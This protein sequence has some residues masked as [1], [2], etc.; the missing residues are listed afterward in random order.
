MDYDRKPRSQRYWL[1]LFLVAL[2][3][4][5]GSCR[6][7]S[8]EKGVADPA[9]ALAR[10]VVATP[11][12]V[13]GRVSH[14]FGSQSEWIFRGRRFA[15]ENRRLEARIAELEG[16]NALLK[17]KTARYDQ[18]RDD[19]GFVKQAQSTLL[20]ADILSRRIDFKFET[21]LVARGANDGVK[22]DSVV[23]T[24]NGLVGRV[25]EVSAGNAVVLLITDLKSGVGA[26]VQR[27]E[28]RA[29]G[30]CKGTNSP[31]LTLTYLDNAADIKPGDEITTSGVGGVFPGGL[32]IGTVLEVKPDPSSAIKTA[33]V[34]PTVNFDRLEEVYIVK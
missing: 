29:L 25:T 26:R 1:A 24:K 12:G 27:A 33:K 23:V 18:L 30:V 2:S 34:R 17:E 19:L 6:N 14:W 32:R 20:P 8:A 13:M 3:V 10:G 28:S 16:E 11:V 15:E 7:R 21:L 4:G 9:S 31:L 22:K 5:I